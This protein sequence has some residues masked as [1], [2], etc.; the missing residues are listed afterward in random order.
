MILDIDSWIAL[1]G[2]FVNSVA[3]RTFS[4]FSKELKTKVSLAAIKGHQ[5]VNEIASE[6]V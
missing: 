6:Q 2:G 3:T 5:T 1:P 4:G